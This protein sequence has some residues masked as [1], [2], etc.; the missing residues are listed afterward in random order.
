MEGA[1]RA[2]TEE[3]IARIREM[4][5]AGQLGPGDRLPREGDLAAA[6]G[7]GRS[8]LREAVRVLT[9]AGVLETRQGAGTY[10]TRLSPSRLLEPAGQAVPLLP[11]EGALQLFDVRR[12]LEPA[13][14]ELAAARMDEARLQELHRLL[15]RCEEAAEVVDRVALPAADQDFHS[16]IVEAV[17]NPFLKSLHENLIR[18]TIQARVWRTDVDAAATRAI[19]T[20]HRDIYAAIEGRDPALAR[21]AATNHL[22]SSEAFLRRALASRTGAV[23]AAPGRN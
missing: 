12:M 11:A 5:I 2:I 8:S 3:A 14:T 23:G 13:A 17:G 10:V 20:Q 7:M 21:T 1:R 6:L 22:L 15:V 4:I 16:C 19:I 9:L 18:G